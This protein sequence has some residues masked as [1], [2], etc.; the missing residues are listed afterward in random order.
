MKNI[1]SPA[2]LSNWSARF[3]LAGVLCCLFAATGRTATPLTSPKE[4]T[5]PRLA[6]NSTR[7]RVVET[8]PSP[9]E[10][11]IRA[12]SPAD[13]PH[14]NQ[15]PAAVVNMPT[16]VLLA[17]DPSPSPFAT[18]YVLYRGT[19]SRSYNT[20]YFTPGT[21]GSFLLVL[22]ETNYF[23]VTATDGLVESTFSNEVWVKA[24]PRPEP[25]LTN[26]NIVVDV[27]GKAG[28]TWTSRMMTTNTFP[29]MEQFEE[30]RAVLTIRRVP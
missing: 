7:V 19:N 16:N 5:V 27:Q 13:Y 25:Q 2:K 12:M 3:G 23:S 21:T 29:A 28:A 24:A 15:A 8:P 9:P 17:W 18:G 30:F 22:G 6:P 26:V 4:R 20:S 11:L 1:F 14:G 10:V